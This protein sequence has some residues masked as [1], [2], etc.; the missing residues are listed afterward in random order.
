MT[1]EGTRKIAISITGGTMKCSFKS[2]VKGTSPMDGSP[3]F[4]RETS[5]KE[6]IDTAI[7]QLQAGYEKWKQLPLEERLQILYKSLSEFES[8]KDEIALELAVLIG[9]PRKHCLNE[10]RGYIERGRYMLDI[11]CTALEDWTI[12]NRKLPVASE[13][14]C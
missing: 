6:E 11:A 1:P 2:V 7:H 9:R 12:D 14:S 13:N 3:V 5:S 4:E 10:V 8:K